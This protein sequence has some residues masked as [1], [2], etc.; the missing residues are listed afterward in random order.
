MAKRMRA[1]ARG[2]SAALEF[3][4]VAPIFFLLMF[5]IIETS[6]IYFAQASLQYAVN[7]V[8]RLVRTGQAQ[9]MSQSTFRTQICNDIA[10]LLA[11]SGN[12]QI[13]VESFANFSAATY[14]APLD[15]NNN[16]NS[17]LDNYQLGT[18]CSVVLVRAFYTWGV[19][20]PLLTPF[21]VNMSSN[22]HLI[23][24]AAAFRNEPFSTGL[25]GC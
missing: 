1:D 5:A 15:S 3:A 8:A 14:P 9:A 13:D 25:S 16:L 19:I 22:N 4:L 12:L 23:Y 7:D 10:P 17:S 24:A 18:A 21:L 11:C 6:I 20:T 2:G